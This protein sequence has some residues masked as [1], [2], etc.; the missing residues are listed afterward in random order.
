MIYQPGGGLYIRADIIP[1][2]PEKY[3][4]ISLLDIEKFPYVKEAVN[5][6]GEDIKFPFDHTESITNFVKNPCR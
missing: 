5:N 1:N 6:P 4:K 2:P 3:V